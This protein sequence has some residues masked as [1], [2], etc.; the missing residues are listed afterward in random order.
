MENGVDAFIQQL[1]DSFRLPPEIEQAKIDE[2]NQIRLNVF[3]GFAGYGGATF[4][5]NRSGIPFRV[6]GFSEF[7]NDAIELY[8]YNFP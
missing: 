8:K 2:Y 6:V 7:D 1:N 4:G 5:L 3:E